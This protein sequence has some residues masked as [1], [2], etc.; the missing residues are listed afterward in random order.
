MQKIQQEDSFVRN[1][2]GTVGF[3]S[4][5]ITGC[6]KRCSYC[7]A[8]RLSNTDEKS[9]KERYLAN[10]NI[11]PVPSYWN[12][13]PDSDPFYPRFWSDRLLMIRK[14]QKPAGIFICDMSE[15]FGDWIPRAWQDAVFETIHA[16]PQHRFYLLTKQPQ[17]LHLFSPYPD[18][19]WVGVSATD[20]TMTQNALLYLKGIQAPIKYIF[21]SPLLGKIDV[22][23][24]GINW[25]IISAQNNPHITPEPSWISVLVKRLNQAGA[26][27]FLKNN[28]NRG[29]GIQQIP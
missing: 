3:S 1:K 27:V 6:L 7:Y 24:T 28:L 23:L 2:D 29:N 8:M 12:T 26:K 4:N 19:C 9:I 5:P 14:R 15:L 21:F 25:G 17:N 20:E 11:A 13:S 18:N 16:C 22:D 10:K